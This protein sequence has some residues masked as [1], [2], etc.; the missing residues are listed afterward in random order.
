MEIV[1]VG[2]NYRHPDGFVVDRPYGSDDFI[3][4]VL[5]SKAR[6]VI[7]GEEIVTE[8]NS[9][10]MYKRGTAHFYGAYN[11]EFVNDWLHF[12]LNSEE[13]EELLS[14]GIVFDRVMH[15]NDTTEISGFIKAIF[16]ERYSGNKNKERSMKCYF[17]LIV[18]KLCELS[19]SSGA[20][21]E[22]PHYNAFCK[23]RGDILLS[24]ERHRTI[25]EISAHL[26]LSAS[27]IQHLY[28]DFFGVSII[29]DLTRSRVE[30]AKY[31]LSATDMTVYSIASAC[32][33]DNDVHFMRIFKKT[34]AMT[35]TDFRKKYKLDSKVV[36]ESKNKNPFCE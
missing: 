29:E 23:L 3:L 17:D 2:Y 22:H 7:N 15:I 1:N 24:P 16:R 19:E 31:L 35:P 12:E 36:L 21:P 18:C 4:L 8:P 14:L 30:Q 11:G 28:K 32:G 25:K 13:Y 27:Y 10:V 5:K 20:E 6:F 33:Y 26:K 9:A 34:T